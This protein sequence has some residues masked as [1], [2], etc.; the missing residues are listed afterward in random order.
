MIRLGLGV[1]PMA[2]QTG[3][4][5]FAPEAGIR[6]FVFLG[7]A[8]S[9]K[10]EIAI[11]IAQLLLARQDGAVHF[12]DLDMTKPLFRSRDLARPLEE[13]GLCFHY[14]EQFMD[15]PT[16]T[17]GVNRLLR[18]SSCYTVLDVG[19]DYIGARSV[20]GYAPLLNAEATAVYYVMNPYR[21]WSTTIDHI[22]RVLG[23]TLGV[24]HVQLEK[25]RLIGNPNLGLQTTAED[26]AEGCRRLKEMVEPYKPLEF[27]CVQD[28][29]LEAAAALT[30]VPLLPL[31]LYLTYPW[32]QPGGL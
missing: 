22:D 17:G 14:E 27:F 18:D 24:S 1:D 15:A 5:A 12:F 7:E 11:N 32:E 20:G 19:G 6:N 23:E 13:A 25:L 10:S 28:T 29:L 3:P 26:V 21:P 8:G 16:I 2:V 30:D 9:G 31:R 4:A